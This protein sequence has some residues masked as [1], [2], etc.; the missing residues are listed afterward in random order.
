M[1]KSAKVWLVGF[2]MIFILSN[3]VFAQSITVTPK[4]IDGKTYVDIDSLKDF[5]NFDYTK[6]QN[7]L[8]IQKK[9]CP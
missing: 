5:L 9:D 1:K 4:E 8:I 7:S 2:I 3:I 6:T